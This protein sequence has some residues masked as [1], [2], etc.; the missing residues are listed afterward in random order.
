VVVYHVLR[1]GIEIGESAVTGF[2][3]TGLTAGA[4][5]TYEVV[6][7]DGAG[8]VSPPSAPLVVTAPASDIQAVERGS[9][10]SYLDDGSDQ[11]TAWSAPAFDDSGWPSGA[12]ELGYGDGDESTVIQS[13]PVRDHY[14]TTY[15]RHS[16]EL[17]DSSIVSSVAV[18]LKRDDGLI[19]YVNGIEVIRE[20]LPDSGVDYLT[21]AP[22]GINGR[23]ERDWLSFVIPAG[24][25][26]DGTNVIAVELH[27]NAPN[28]SDVSF[29]FEMLLNPS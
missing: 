29:D 3:D 6:A 25:L 21:E 19:V 10:W 18:D 17:P 4:T 26:V 24:V 23:A 16:F 22:S 15:F 11:G 13:G 27:Q 5:Y 20:N 1:D 14:I 7:E 2:D 9:V 28:S 12:A 8:N